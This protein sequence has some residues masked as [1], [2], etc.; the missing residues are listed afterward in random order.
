MSA[1]DR[2]PFNRPEVRHGAVEISELGTTPERTGPGARLRRLGA[3]ALA[4]ALGFSAI[5]GAQAQDP[6]PA[7]VAPAPAPA[8]ETPAPPPPAPVAAPEPTAVTLEPT[9]E[10]A[11]E[12]PQ[13]EQDLAP[14]AAPAE[15]PFKP[16][17]TVGIGLR[18][19]LSLEFANDKT[20]LTLQ[21][22]LDGGFMFRPFFAGQLTKKVS[23]FAQA[24]GSPTSFHMIDAYA[25]LAFLPQLSL[26]VGQHIPANDRNNNCGPFFNNSWNFAAVHS[27][28]MD[29][30]AR[31]RGFTLW[32]M[33]GGGVIKYHASMVDLQPGNPISNARYAGRVMLSLLS[34]EKGYYLSGTYFGKQDVLSI[35]GVASY[36]SGL[37]VKDGGLP[38]NEFLGL[39]AD[40]LFEKNL[41]AVGTITVEAGYWNFNGTGKNYKVPGVMGAPPVFGG[42]LTGFAG[43]LSGNV[44]G[45][46]YE[47]AVSWLSPHKI[48]SGQLQ[49]NARIQGFDKDAGDVTILDAGLGYIIDGY[50]HLYRVN[51]QHVTVP[52]GQDS[53]SVQIGGQ[54]L[55]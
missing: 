49:P 46:S 7:P 27:Y 31:D 30:A 40:L 4:S 23:V 47:V 34:P 20:V 13:P 33:L 16:K 12:P 18:T 9:E 21:D 53:N 22:S 43:A 11:A 6:A 3:L 14:P 10:R 39:S 24:D 50:A 37:K 15:E 51:F 42:G 28:P 2:R 48:G 38:N 17:L 45:Q 41:G 8:P 26:V 35:G 52:N 32:G 54:F 44:T 36:Q 55:L 25:E 1:R 29:A 19:G 5:P